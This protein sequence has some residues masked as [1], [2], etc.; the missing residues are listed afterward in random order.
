MDSADDAV[1]SNASIAVNGGIFE[2]ASG[3]DAFHADETLTVTAG[4]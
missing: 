4:T 1:H 2:I 3:D